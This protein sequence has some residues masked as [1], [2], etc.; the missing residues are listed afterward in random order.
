MYR[1]SAIPAA[2]NESHL[3]MYDLP[4]PVIYL[5]LPVHAN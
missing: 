3:T 5:D 2:S 4:T 1:L